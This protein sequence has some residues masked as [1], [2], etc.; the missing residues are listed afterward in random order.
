MSTLSLE[1]QIETI[2][3]GAT[4]PQRTMLYKY[5]ESL[6]LDSAVKNHPLRENIR[7][8]ER[9]K[10]MRNRYAD[11]P[12]LRTKHQKHMRDYRLR[13]KQEIEALKELVGIQQN[14]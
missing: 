8:E 3:K 10:Y 4:P 11:S 7:K 1:E 13:K 12:E 6:C 5:V 2:F 14:P 9:N